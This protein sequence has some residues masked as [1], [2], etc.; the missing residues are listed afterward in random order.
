MKEY[1]ILVLARAGPHRELES[2]VITVNFGLARA[3]SSK[4]GLAN[5]H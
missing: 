1:D 3:S 5:E 4:A 2:H